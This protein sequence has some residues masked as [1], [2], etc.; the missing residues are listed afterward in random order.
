[1]FC[2]ALSISCNNRRRLLQNAAFMYAGIPQPMTFRA[3]TPAHPQDP[4]SY[5]PLLLE[6]QKE[7]GFDVRTLWS[8][9]GVKAVKKCCTLSH[10]LAAYFAKAN[11][12]PYAL[13]F[14][15]DAWPML[16]AAETYNAVLEA[17]GAGAGFVKC[18]FNGR[19]DGPE[20]DVKVVPYRNTAGSH[21][22]VI[23]QKF[24]DG[25]IKRALAEFAPADYVVTDEVQDAFTLN[26]PAFIQFNSSLYSD[27]AVNIS[28]KTSGQAVYIDNHV[29]GGECPAGYARFEDVLKY[30]GEIDA[31]LAKRAKES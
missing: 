16:G 21:A 2:H 23:F 30:M 27:Q 10:M 7:Y 13:V 6:M 18:G 31:T 19:L 17:G 26:R 15:D 1:M 12:W 9:V 20:A 28:S 24:Y 22:Y 25:F 29:Y 14:E 4:D 8:G 3:V 11:G 5:G